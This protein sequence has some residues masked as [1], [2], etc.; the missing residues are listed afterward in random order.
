MQ[1]V[2]FKRG[3][4]HLN[5]ELLLERNVATVC[6]ENSLNNFTDARV[7]NM[8]LFDSLSE[9]KSE[10]GMLETSSDPLSSNQFQNN[11]SCKI[12]NDAYPSDQ[13]KYIFYFNS[14]EP[15]EI[16]DETDEQLTKNEDLCVACGHVS[17]YEF[18]SFPINVDI[19][20]QWAKF[21]DINLDKIK[22]H[23]RLCDAH[24]KPEDYQISMQR[25]VLMATSVPTLRPK[26]KH[27]F[28]PSISQS[29]QFG[30]NVI[31]FSMPKSNINTS[32]D[33]IS[34]LDFE[35][36][37]TVADA[38]NK[39][40]CGNFKDITNNQDTI[41][42]KTAKSTTKKN[43]KHE[44]CHLLEKNLR[45]EIFRLKIRCSRLEDTVANFEN[46]IKQQVEECL[47]TR[48]N[49]SGNVTRDIQN[50]TSSINASSEISRH[51]LCN[52]EARTDQ[53]SV[54]ETLVGSA[55]QVTENG[56]TTDSNM[57]SLKISIGHPQKVEVKQELFT[58]EVMLDE[59]A[60]MVAE[61]NH[62]VNSTIS[63]REI[64]TELLHNAKANLKQFSIRVDAETS[65][66]VT[67]NNRYPL[68]TSSAENSNTRRCSTEDPL[69]QHF[70]EAPPEPEYS[71]EGS[72]SPKS[73]I[74]SSE[75]SLKSRRKAEAQPGCSKDQENSDQGRIT[76]SAKQNK[77]L[78][79]VKKPTRNSGNGSNKVTVEMRD[80]SKPFHC[81]VCN[82]Q[83]T[84][85]RSF[86]A[87]ELIHSEEKPYK[88]RTCGT[89]F[90]SYQSKWIHEQ[91]GHV[92]R[93]CFECA[94]CGKKYS[95]KESLF[96]H[97]K[98]HS[99]PFACQICGKSFARKDHLRQH[100]R[101]HSE[102]KSYKCGICDARYKHYRHKVR[103]ERTHDGG[104]F[105]CPDCGKQFPYKDDLTKHLRV[106]SG[107]KPLSSR[108]RVHFECADCGKKLA[109]R[110]RLVEHLRIHSGV[111]P[112]SCRTCSKS[113]ARKGD[114][115]DHQR[116]HSKKKPF[117]CRICDQR[118]KHHRNRAVHESIHVE[119]PR[120][121]CA[122]C[123]RKFRA[124]RNLA[125]HIS[126]KCT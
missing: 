30:A 53:R 41:P 113:F 79:S 50:L 14:N 61:E 47:V 75:K 29:F 15:Y 108:E 83:F 90:K 54:R 68:T 35:K 63:P 80:S 5:G 67:E 93:A 118:F 94:V 98:L 107:V 122:H 112:F 111:K 6:D 92:E 37:T 40:L 51:N 87:H 65:R 58:E 11:I 82:K 116:T 105:E 64:S 74:P 60:E 17:A 81:Q 120:F 20:Q 71:D 49:T 36:N 32:Q 26:V 119:G 44:K 66:N 21:C 4:R 9:K 7:N 57:S 18:F 99:T 27:N 52:T 24:F 16:Q 126:S 86:K 102:E 95:Y 22:P 46:K 84:Y 91:R 106:H 125:K 8:D 88:C 45:S 89:R 23:F 70:E 34:S 109:R 78:P 85:R 101:M 76:R 19:R 1:Q 42:P 115:T 123:G 39:R 77:H 117:K 96:T 2:L 97:L 10:Q 48:A 73:T 110:Q 3:I 28:T 25:R 100:E 55:E 121:E 103:H 31:S 104:F 56:Y 43:L 38:P 12:E 13:E 59:P 33:T 114:L 69:E 124:K 62:F 72:K